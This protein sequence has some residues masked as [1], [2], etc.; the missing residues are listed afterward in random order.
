MI[1]CNISGAPDSGKTTICNGLANWCESMGYK[2]V[3][4]PRITTRAMRVGERSN[5]EYEFI[6]ESEFFPRLTTNEILVDSVR[7]FEADGYSH[8]F[9]GVPHPRFWPKQ[10]DEVGLILSTLGHLSPDIKAYLNKY[11]DTFNRSMINIFLMVSEEKLKER[12]VEKNVNQSRRQI[13]KG[14]E[15]KYDLRIWNNGTSE[16]CVTK[17]LKS[18]GLYRSTDPR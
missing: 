18:I 6:L 4:I 11:R 15:K 5:R 14:L 3:Y 13:E 7:G 9:T 2:V 12:S 16:E 17:I 1:H 8:Y 10:T